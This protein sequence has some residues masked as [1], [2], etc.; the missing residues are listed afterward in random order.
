MNEGVDISFLRRQQE[1]ILDELRQMRAQIAD[2]CLRFDYS[3]QHQ[4]D[5]NVLVLDQLVEL[6]KK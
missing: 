4:D 2:L 1:R 5:I 6:R 3:G